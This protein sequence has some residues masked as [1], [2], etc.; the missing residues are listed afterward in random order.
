V[1]VEA[2]AAAIVGQ[3]LVP[4]L[5]K[6]AQAVTEQVGSAL[7]DLAGTQTAAVA[8]RIWG[9]VKAAFAGDDELVVAQFEKRPEVA[10]PL[11]EELLKECLGADAD[12]AAELEALLEEQPAGSTS[13]VGT[14]IGQYVG[15]VVVH[16]Q[17]QAPVTGLIVNPAAQPPPAGG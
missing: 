1:G 3:V 15:H 11:F 5:S 2:L 4:L 7:G 8:A 13:S 9:R 14:I 17:V 6:G 10:A 12:L 16:G